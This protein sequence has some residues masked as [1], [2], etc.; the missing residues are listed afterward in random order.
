MSDLR[1]A[2]F[3]AA[4]A[5][6]LGALTYAALRYSNEERAPVRHAYS[7]AAASRPAMSALEFDLPAALFAAPYVS[8]A[9]DSASLLVDASMVRAIGRSGAFTRAATASTLLNAQRREHDARTEFRAP[10]PLPPPLAACDAPVA[11]VA[12]IVP[13]APWSLPPPLAACDAPVAPWSLPPAACDAPIMSWSLPPAACDVPQSPYDVHLVAPVLDTARTQS[14]AAPRDVHVVAP[15]LGTACTQP[16]ADAER[17]AAIAQSTLWTHIALDGD[18]ADYAAT[19]AALHA[20]SVAP[21]ALCIETIEDYEPNSREF[22][23]AN[24]QS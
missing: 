15:V 21:P 17:R 23:A 8:H 20:H 14:D 12:P 16:D 9:H 4:A 18:D 11:L 7:A 19:V 10:A 6:G 2:F 13:V 24:K 22:N 3:R 5:L 1:D